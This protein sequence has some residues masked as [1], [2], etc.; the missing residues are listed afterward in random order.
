MVTCIEVSDA[1]SRSTSNCGRDCRGLSRLL[2]VQEHGHKIA[3][4]YHSRFLS[5]D[6]E[7]F[8]FLFRTIMHGMMEPFKPLGIRWAPPATSTKSEYFTIPYAPPAPLI[9]VM[10]IFANC[11]LSVFSVLV[12]SYDYWIFLSLFFLMKN[13]NIVEYPLP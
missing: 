4:H 10:D 12:S 1:L 6:G 9:D 3:A 5:K 8:V 13:M 2:S 11:F 7:R